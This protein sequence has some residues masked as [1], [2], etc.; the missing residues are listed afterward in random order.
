MGFA[1]ECVVLILSPRNSVHLVVT[2]TNPNQARIFANAEEAAGEVMG[3]KTLSKYP[4]TVIP[5][6]GAF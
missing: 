6:R 2:P 3:S 4:F 5:L 1:D